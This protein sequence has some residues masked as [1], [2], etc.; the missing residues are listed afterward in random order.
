MTAILSY[1][2]LFLLQLC[3]INFNG[4]TILSQVKNA[5]CKAMV[6]KQAMKIDKA[7]LLSIGRAESMVIAVRFT[8][9]SG[10][11]TTRNFYLASA[12]DLKLYP[13]NLIMQWQQIGELAVLTISS[14]VVVKDLFLGQTLSASNF[15]GNFFD[16][17]PG[18]RKRSTIKG[19]AEA[20]KGNLK[21][22]CLNQF[23]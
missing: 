4:D 2:T 7:S 9:A 20:L 8:T 6:S 15:S 11:L 17:V 18:E 23:Q 1:K 10:Q 12:K 21:Y 19:D 3:L 5:S 14:D 13:V 22:Y 16:L